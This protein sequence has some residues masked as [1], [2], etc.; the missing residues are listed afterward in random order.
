M[1]TARP[2]AVIYARYSTDL[3]NEHSIRD[4]IAKLGALTVTVTVA[5]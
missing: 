5:G 4:Q 2:R 1:T 3:Q